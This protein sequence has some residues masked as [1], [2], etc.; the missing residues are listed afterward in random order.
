MS[1][2][3]VTV[4]VFYACDDRFVKYTIVSLTSLKA[5]ASRERGTSYRIHIL[6]SDLSDLSIARLSDLSDERF[7]ICF[8][9]V[10]G[11]LAALADRFPLRDYYSKTTY[12]RMFIA[13]MF[14]DYEKVLYLDSDTVVCGD[15]SKL[16]QTVLTDS[17][18]LAAAHEQVMVQN[19]SFGSY[20]EQ[21]VGVNRYNFFNAGVLLLNC[22]RFR[23]L[24]MLERFAALLDFYDFR[25]TQDEDYLNVLCKDHV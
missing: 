20:V 17:D 8:E 7:E 6:H 13:D 11:Y 16:Y 23:E 14:P 1:P 3:P 25:V 21:A 10:T 15:V 22:T 12:Y 9:D 2:I 18:Y 4:P 5:N 24:R 19:D